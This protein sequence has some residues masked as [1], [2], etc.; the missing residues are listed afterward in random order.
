[1]CG[2]RVS[3]CECTVPTS[4]TNTLHKYIKQHNHCTTHNRYTTMTI[5]EQY[6][7][8]LAKLEKELSAKEGER[9][10]LLR[11]CDEMMTKL[12]AANSIA[13]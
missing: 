12:E 7:S 13:G 5:Q 8:R 6:K 2:G 11:M 10:Q 4:T 1:M 3:T 9:E